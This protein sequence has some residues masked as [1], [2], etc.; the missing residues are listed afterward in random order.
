MYSSPIMEWCATRLFENGRV[1]SAHAKV[2]AGRVRGI[3]V[4]EERRVDEYRRT[5]RVAELR[6]QKG[7]QLP[8][9]LDAEVIAAT[10]DY[11]VVT[12]FENIAA[13]PLGTPASV[14]QAWYL[15]PASNEDLE[16]AEALVNRLSGL[17]AQLGHPIDLS[18]ELRPK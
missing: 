2:Q 7:N 5:L 4:L 16:R 8:P 14:R 10:S 11:L 15:V 6:P 1:K 12:G 3:L 17:L 9:L 18:E 13:G